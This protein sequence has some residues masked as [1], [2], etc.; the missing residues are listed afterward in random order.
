MKQWQERLRAFL[1]V[2]NGVVGTI[3]GGNAEPTGK[4]NIARIWSFGGQ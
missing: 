3:G 4:I 1:G 2:G